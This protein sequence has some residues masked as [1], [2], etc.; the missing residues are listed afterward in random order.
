MKTESLEQQNVKQAYTQP[1]LTDLGDLKSQTLN[2]S[3]ASPGADG[4]VSTAT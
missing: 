2:V 3:S 1:V 4:G